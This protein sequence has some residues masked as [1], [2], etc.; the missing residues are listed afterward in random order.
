MFRPMLYVD[1]KD[2]CRAYENYAKKILNGE[3]SDEKNSLAHIFNVCYPEPITI[4]EL[5]ETV[6]NAI[7]KFSNNRIKP[8]IKVIDTGKPSLFTAKDKNLIRVDVSKAMNFLGL[9]KLKSPKES[10]EEIVK[11]RLQKSL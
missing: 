5:A 2:V 7:I 8:K 4:L 9:G 11:K 10:I 6:K 3:V 1:V